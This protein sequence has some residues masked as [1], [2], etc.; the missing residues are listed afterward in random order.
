[1][2]MLHVWWACPW[3]AVY[4]IL[5]IE[6]YQNSCRLI[7]CV[8]IWEKANHIQRFDNGFAYSVSFDI[9]MLWLVD[10]INDFQ[11]IV[12]SESSFLVLFKYVCLFLL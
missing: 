1:M 11:N 2:D 3:L 8:E 12:F 10:E 9:Y 7:Y 4:I 6:T 5:N